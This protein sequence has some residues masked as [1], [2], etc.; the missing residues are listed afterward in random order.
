LAEALFV[1]AGADVILGQHAF[2]RGIV[3]FDRAHGVVHESADRRLRRARFQM[4]P[5]RL[6]RNPEDARGLVLVWVFGIGALSALSIEFGMFGFEGVRDVFEEDQ[7]EDDMLVLR[8]VHV[9]PQRIRGG[10]E[11]LLKP[12]R[13]SIGFF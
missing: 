9:V 4:G 12:K 1:E 10:P 3:S 6:L 11:F 13:G 2:E 7:T 8:R 5:S